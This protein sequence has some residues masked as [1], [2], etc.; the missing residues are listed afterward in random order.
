MSIS[1]VKADLIKGLS[2]SN[3][4]DVDVTLGFL[5]AF[6]YMEDIGMAYNPSFWQ[7]TTN[8]ADKAIELPGY[9]WMEG[10]NIG[11]GGVIAR[12]D[13]PSTLSYYTILSQPAAT[14][15]DYAMWKRVSGSESEIGYEAIDLANWDMWQVKLS[16][17]GT[18]IKA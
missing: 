3:S 2:P 9:V 6:G 1:L 16:C 14:T 12:C 17:N 7:T 15:K 10:V 8:Y 4:L 13:V 5:N 18:A 11:V